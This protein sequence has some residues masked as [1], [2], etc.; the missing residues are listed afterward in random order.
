MKRTRLVGFFVLWATTMSSGCPSDEAAPRPR[1]SVTLSAFPEEIA[2]DGAATSR[3]TAVVTATDRTQPEGRIS[4]D[5]PIGGVFSPGF[6]LDNGPHVEVRLIDGQ[7][8]LEF[9]CLNAAGQAVAGNFELTVRFQPDASDDN[10]AVE[11]R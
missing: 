1:Y 3:L 9:R 5:A 11:L 6:G 2:A 7:Y 4:F 10:E 8:V